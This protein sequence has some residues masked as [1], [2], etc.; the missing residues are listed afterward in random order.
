MTWTEPGER[1]LH[2][3]WAVARSCHHIQ[4]V[5]LVTSSAAGSSVSSL[6]VAGLI[7]RIHLSRKMG[8]SVW[9]PERHEVPERVLWGYLLFTP[10]CFRR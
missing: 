2:L 5:P 10:F 8:K 7:T 6:R 4:A 3:P 9:G 1:D